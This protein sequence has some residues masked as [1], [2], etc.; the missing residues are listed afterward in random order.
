MSRLL[1]TW[2]SKP[3]RRGL[4]NPLAGYKQS[5]RK[6]VGGYVRACSTITTSDGAHYGTRRRIKGFG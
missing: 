4:A 5:F 2:I 3:S 1:T 6:I